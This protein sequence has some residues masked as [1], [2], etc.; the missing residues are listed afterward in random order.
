[1][2]VGHRRNLPQPAPTG[3]SVVVHASNIA[4]S[5]SKQRFFAL[6]E[7]FPDRET[8]MELADKLVGWPIKK[9]RQGKT[10]YGTMMIPDDNMRNIWWDQW[11]SGEE[12]AT[13]R[14]NEMMRA[15]VKAFLEMEQTL[16]KRGALKAAIHYQ[17]KALN[18]ELSTKEQV[19]YK[20]AHDAAGF[21]STSM[22]DSKQ[23]VV[24]AG[25]LNINF[26]QRPEKK[27]SAVQKKRQA[28][29]LKEGV[30]IGEYR[31]LT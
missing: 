19:V 22:G 3:K 2:P 29:T 8:V 24:Q 26:G 15:R 10:P 23:T 5:D 6:C 30:V 17:K 25:K 18:D 12:K 4:F 20:Y 14:T 21:L 27:P 11:L 9:T 13:E 16:A 28:Q 7:Q 31:E 1:M